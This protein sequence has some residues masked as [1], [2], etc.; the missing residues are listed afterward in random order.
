MSPQYQCLLT[1]TISS[2]NLLTCPHCRH[3]DSTWQGLIYL[4]YNYTHLTPGTVIECQVELVNTSYVQSRNIK[5]K[6]SKLRSEGDGNDN[7]ENKPEFFTEW[8]FCICNFW[9]S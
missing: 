4:L 1:N 8:L 7:F 9:R 3:Q 5:F 6:Q 2:T